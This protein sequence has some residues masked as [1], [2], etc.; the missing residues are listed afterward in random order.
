MLQGEIR[1]A[2]V[3]PMET[4]ALRG[5]QF[6]IDDSNVNKGHVSLVHSTPYARRLYYHPEYNFSHE[7]AENAK[8]KWFD[9]WVN[10]SKKKRAQE[11]Y[12]QMF[13]RE[14]GI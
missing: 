14:S 9:D 13:R 11:I 10:G 1:D 5:E 7:F 6:F 8:G 12:N 4:G 2:Q 3:I